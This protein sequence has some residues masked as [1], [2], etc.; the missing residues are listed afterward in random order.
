MSPDSITQ[1]QATILIAAKQYIEEHKR[2][3]FS[4]GSW[5]RWQ[6]EGFDCTQPQVMTLAGNR[7]GKTMSAGF[8]TACDLTG[9]YPDNWKG[10]RFEHAPNVLCMGVDNQQ[11]KD[12]VQNELFGECVDDNGRKILTGGWVHRDEIGRIEWSQT[13][14]LARR[15]EVL[16]KYGSAACTLRAYTQ[17]KTGHGTLSFAGTSLDLIWVDE[18]PPDTLVGQLVMRTMT[19]NYGKGGRIR[20]TMTPELG[21]TKLVTD[22]MENRERMQHLVGPVSWD[23]CPHLTEELQEQILAGIPEHERDMRR[24]GVPYFGSGLVFTVP[25]ERITEP[26]FN[27]LEM[28]WLR[29]IRAID[30][31][32][33]HP[34]AIAWLA[35][36]PEID[37]VYLLRTYSSKGELPPV[38]AAVANSYLPFAPIVFPHDVDQREKGSGKTLREYYYDS[39][40]KNAI[41]FENPD[42]SRFVEPGIIQMQNMMLTDRFKAVRDDCLDFYREL[43]LFHRVDG[44]IN[45]LN[46]DVISAVRYGTMMIKK[47]GVA[48]NPQGRRVGVRTSFKRLG[49]M[50]K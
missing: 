50:I 28:P 22:F 2:D 5:Y 15:V 32:I 23:E 14:G 40:L 33:D 24:K 36:D 19:G 9:D 6:L 30:L 41:D 16:G 48:Y 4:Y 45:P 35:Y 26:R 27:P 34:T 18:C 10:F 43:R 20:Y 17:S 1:E 47:R 13:P 25:E 46:D 39:G 49:G 8:H 7:T 31:G 38:H 42:G 44:K 11:L 21:A 37:R 3:F 12:V 29:Y